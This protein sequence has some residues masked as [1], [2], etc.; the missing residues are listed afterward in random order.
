MTAILDTIESPCD[1]KGVTQRELA[2]L[3][4]ELREKII[5]VCARNGGHLAPSLGVVELTLALHRVFDS[6]ADKIIWD[7]G[8]QAYAHKLLTGRRDRFATLRTLG[9]I[10]GFPKRCES[11][12]DAFDTGHTSTSISAALGFAV[13]RDL[14]GERNKVVAVIGD[15]SM[16]G[17]LAY[18]GLNNAGHL[19][20]DLVVVLNDNEMSIAENVGALS[21]F[22]N[23]TVTSEF[24]HTM[25]KDLEGFLG[26]LDRIGHGVLKVAKRAEESLKGLFTPG[27]L[28]EA[29]G[30]EYIGPIDGHDTARLMETFEK[31]KRF[32]DAVLIHVLTKKG[33]GYPPAEE[34]PAL[35]HGVGPFELETGKVIKGKGGAASYTGVFGEAIRKIAAEDERVIALTAAMP[36]GTG[37][38]P[39]AADYPTRF[40]DVGIAE[41]HGV[42]FAA[43]LAAEGYRPVFAVYSSFLQRAYD[44]VFHDVC[45]QNLPV[46][47]AIDRAGVVGSDGPTHHGLFDLA[48]L[49]HL[50][51]M[52]V[53]APKDENELQ[54]LLLTAIEHDGPAAVRYPRGNGY[55]VSLDQTCSVLP[56][57]KG[58]ILREGLDG[59]LLAIGSTVYPAREAAEALAAEGIDLA[60]VNARFV[61]PLDRD[62]ILSLARTTGRLIIVEENVIQGGF[63]TAV[64][65]LLEEEGINGVKVL[66]LGY[67][68]R[69]VE[70]G[71]QHELRAQYGL[72]AP[73][74]TARVRTFMKG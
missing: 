57:G 34:K 29:F 42:T 70:Q 21:N 4:A 41:Q 27:M 30:F 39:F 67:P 1:L 20:K 51:N 73:G 63:G 14:R 45:L 23:R 60:V 58:E 53:M 6:P 19:N 8:H 65:E 22:L 32:D 25:K 15:G 33:R 7:V 40:F 44:Q 71:E 48:Y 54:H 36:D 69:Y 3:A 17:G 49:R 37:L 26:G 64:L 10:S 55:G 31:V 5:T 9:G 35:F 47:F 68:D 18:E 2:Q 12:H 46:T 24:V 74:I 56:I 11:S 43:G 16:T 28:F 50:P 38:T 52:V 72:D 61:K 13:A 59:A 62:L 66:R